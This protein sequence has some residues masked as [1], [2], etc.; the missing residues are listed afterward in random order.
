MADKKT[1]SDLMAMPSRKKTKDISE[2]K[3]GKNEKVKKEK[4][5]KISLDKLRKVYKLVVDE[6]LP[7]FDDMSEEA[8]RK[9][10]IAAIKKGLR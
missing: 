6:V 4:K 3:N 8:E 9:K 10:L 7:D 2:I 1:A 5:P